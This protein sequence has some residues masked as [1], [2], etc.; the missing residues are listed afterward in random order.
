VTLSRTVLPRLQP[1]SRNGEVALKDEEAA[2]GDACCFGEPQAG[3]V[4]PAG[5]P[6]AGRCRPV[7][8]AFFA[9]RVPVGDITIRFCCCGRPVST[10]AGD[11]GGAV[12]LREEGDRGH[13][14]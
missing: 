7:L 12:L 10:G 11:S 8:A 6:D 2:C 3:V 13:V 5:L 4:A 9:E 1:V 14:S